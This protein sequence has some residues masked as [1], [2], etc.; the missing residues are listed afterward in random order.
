LR[1]LFLKVF[2][3]FWLAMILVIGAL[4]LTSYVTRP[5]PP[6]PRPPQLIEGIMTAYSRSAVEIFE[7][8]GREGLDFFLRHIERE[9]HLRAHLLDATGKDLT[10]GDATPDEKELAARVISTGDRTSKL[11]GGGVVIEAR[12]ETS[13]KGDRYAFVAMLPLGPPIQSGPALRRTGS[14]DSFQRFLPPGPLNFLLGDTPTALALRVLAV[15]LTAGLLCY[16]LARYIVSPVVKLRAVTRQVS[17]G[18][19]SA[20]VGPL[21]GK[22]RDELADMGRD[23]DAMAAQIE[24]LLSAQQRLLRDISHELR[25]PLAR[26]G[27]ALDL[28]RKRTGPEAESYLAR[29]ERE[30]ARLNEMIGQLLSLSRWEAG[31]DVLHRQPLN[32]AAL[33]REVAEDADFE[34]RSQKRAVELVE[35]DECETTGTPTLLRSAVENVVRNAV[36]HTPE[37]TSVKVSLRCR[38]KDDSDEAL[39]SVRDEGP[40]VPD[41]ALSEIFRPFYRVDDSRTR[42][43]GGAGLGLAITERAVRLHGGTI[44]AE[45]LKGGGFIVE[46]RLPLASSSLLSRNGTDEADLVASPC[47]K[48]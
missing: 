16:M 4:A 15:I 5:V 44:S 21:L 28:L 30:S 43:T 32:F 3:W 48:K 34:A 13:S 31:A 10:G 19:L 17:G 29:I 20:R 23:F 25:S 8:E 12:P 2:L 38:R 33:V 27:V 42:E 6:P 11:L 35:C 39:L 37:G 1:S 45:N 14:P 47:E 7:R 46:I 36:R 40:G 9:A 41:D 24:A 22:R 18:D 26:L